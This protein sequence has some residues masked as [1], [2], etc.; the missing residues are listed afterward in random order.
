[1]GIA[2]K[3]SYERA[4]SRVKRIKG[5]YNHLF[6]YVLFLILWFTLAGRF[7]GFIGTSIGNADDGFFEWANINLWLN[8]L[9]WGLIVVIHAIV[10]FGTTGKRIRRWENQKIEEFMNEDVEQSNQRYE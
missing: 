2:N 5:F 1:M 8:P 10:I 9:I 7:F 4:Q 3:S 6:I